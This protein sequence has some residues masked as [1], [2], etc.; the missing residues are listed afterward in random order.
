[1][2]VQ[3]SGAA[4][5]QPRNL[6]MK[7]NVRGPRYTSYPTALQFQEDF[8]EAAYRRMWQQASAE[9][10]AAPLSLYVHVPFC[11][12]LCYFCACNKV[13]TRQRT[14][15][16]RYL[17]YLGREIRLQAE[18]LDA[19]RPV[20]QLHWGGGT[21]TVLSGAETMELMHGLSRHF[22]LVDDD[23]REYSIEVDPRTVDV[24]RLALLR[25]LGFNR[26]SL[27]IQDFDPTVQR[28]IN[29]VQS[30]DQICGIVDAIRAHE[31]RSLSLDLIYGLPC[32]SSVSF[33]Q[34][35]RRVIA[36]TPD[37]VSLY[38][39]AHLPQRFKPQRA[40]DQRTLPGPMARL[41]M[42]DMASDMLGRAGY[43]HIGMDHF[44]RPDDELALAQREGRLQRNF[45]GYSVKHAP[46]LLA[47]GMSGISS[48]DRAYAQNARQLD[49][50]YQALDEGRLPV[51]RG[52]AM[53]EEDC[54]RRHVIMALICNLHCDFA[55]FEQRFGRPF[56]D[57]FQQE[58]PELEQLQCDGLLT[59]SQ[60]ALTV[61]APG[62]KL[63]RNICMRFDRY[64][65]RSG[66][67]QVSATAL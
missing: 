37:R 23:D 48:T 27:G 18:L 32:Q 63:L 40:L 15:I 64:L 9:H 65:A 13:V 31:F 22:R 1:M 61:T 5:A 4:A 50:Y 3:A 6:I 7:Y 16:Q 66:A 33:G 12:H 55:D 11:E 8:D 60:D 49:R 36:L 21:P 35:L 45:Q 17:G 28:A 20:T 42:L 39:Y 14:A 38:G 25:G 24:E 26:I 10:A 56:Q 41:T 2:S 54:L 47:L 46:D 34:T 19:D 52:V 51:E 53:S 59:L 44:V 58:W 57:C 67:A 43:V 29:R 30:L 62:R